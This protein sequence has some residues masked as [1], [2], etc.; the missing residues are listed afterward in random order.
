MTLPRAAAVGLVHTAWVHFPSLRS[1]PG[2]EDGLMSG[3]GSGCHF[4]P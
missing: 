3:H 2:S 4:V 1:C